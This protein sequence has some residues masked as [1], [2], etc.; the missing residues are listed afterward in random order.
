[1]SFEV[2]TFK[3]KIYSINFLFYLEKNWDPYS[4]V[5]ERNREQRHDWFSR[6][7]TQMDIYNQTKY[8]GKEI[9]QWHLISHD[10]LVLSYTLWNLHCTFVPVCSLSKQLTLDLTDIV[11]SNWVLIKQYISQS[12][13]YLLPWLIVTLWLIR[14]QIL[15][16][17]K[18]IC[19]S[20]LSQ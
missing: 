9:H 3:N 12:F 16:K 5:K 4:I 10:M 2:W 8:S 13:Y 6:D 14:T 1:M 7:H 19:Y 11:N 18:I 20:L 17:I 15:K